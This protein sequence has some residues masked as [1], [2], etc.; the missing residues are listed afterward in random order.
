MGLMQN[1]LEGFSVALEPQNLLFC[2]V[3]VLL[4]TVI[5][6]LPGMGSA[7]GVAVLL[8]LTLTLE[9]VTA[10]IMLAGLYYGTEY[11][12]TISA[13]LISTPGDGAALVTVIDGHQ[14]ALKGRAG[15]ALAIAAI[16]SFV[17][18]TISVVFLSIL[19]PFFAAV[20]LNFGPPEMFALM[21]LGL[22]TVG[23]IVGK[24]PLK[25]ILM[26]VVGAM[27]A[28]VGIDSQ[29]STLR[30]VFDRSE[31]YSGVSLVAVV[32]GIV[33][34]AELA[35]QGAAGQ[36]KPI[37]TRFR[38]MLLSRRDLRQA[39]GA[40]G[41]G[42]LLGFII[43]VLPGAGPTLATFFT[44]G[45]EQ[46]VAK[47]KSQFG[48]GDIR[49]VASPEAANNAAVNGAFVPTLTLGIPG[50]ATTAILLGAFIL[51][52]IQPGPQLF[53]QQGDLVWGLITSFFIGNLILLVLNLPLAP[54]FA[55]VLRIKYTYLYPVVLVIAIVAAYAVSARMFDAFLAIGLAVLGVIMK[56]HGYPVA[57]LV[58]GL[59]LGGM[60]EAEL[61]RTLAIGDGT[62]GIFLERPIALLILGLALLLVVV[63]QVIRRVR[64]RPR[65]NQDQHT[66][67]ETRDQVGT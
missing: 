2:L 33:A 51:F 1:I 18:G 27:I 14:M 4:G 28:M 56:Q 31:L 47:D 41:R 3:G 62:M 8:P 23:G 45:V 44:Y 37:R 55:S 30:F 25:G 16:S 43:G 13:V 54:V 48:H 66:L 34:L 50:S 67:E 58:L 5:G 11:G 52:G 7:S 29:T 32:V 60:V 57:P 24:N 6:M 21:V 65:G 17:A 46:R 26:A 53:E 38:D 12:S 9:P 61:R 39:S 19:A 63:P 59:V 40:I 64:K 42:G 49:G 35:T 15:Q 20:S 22:L 10:L 36:M